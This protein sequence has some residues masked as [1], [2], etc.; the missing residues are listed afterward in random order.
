VAIRI[1]IQIATLVRRVLAEVH[2][3][4]MLLVLSKCILISSLSALWTGVQ[5]L[6]RCDPL[7]CQDNQYFIFKNR[8]LYS[9]II[10]IQHNSQSVV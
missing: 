7:V 10:N 1:R 8:D 4:P 3:V 2:T 5:Q 9:Q 6:N